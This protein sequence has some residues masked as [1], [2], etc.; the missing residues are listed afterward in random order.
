M[1]T[2]VSAADTMEEPLTNAAP[3]ERF[4]SLLEENRKIVYKVA[5]TYTRNPAE[6]ED[7]AQE[8]AVQP[9]LDGGL[10]RSRSHSPSGAHG[11]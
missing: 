6:R 7:L 9:V 2:L 3:A 8:I 10:T 1:A 11:R 4:V 5:A